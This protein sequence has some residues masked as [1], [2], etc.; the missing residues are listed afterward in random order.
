MGHVK[1]K[2]YEFQI[3]VLEHVRKERK[4]QNRN[5]AFIRVVAYESGMRVGSDR[6]LVLVTTN[7][8]YFFVKRREH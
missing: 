4:R 1:F 5:A 3:L 6:A 7:Y 8:K 2:T